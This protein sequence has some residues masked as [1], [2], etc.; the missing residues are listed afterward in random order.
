LH[1]IIFV[2]TAMLLS[3]NI[4]HLAAATPGSSVKKLFFFV[5]VKRPNKLERFK[6]FISHGANAGKA[7]SLWPVC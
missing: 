2:E 7:R 3:I 5:T 6:S 1:Q 4:G